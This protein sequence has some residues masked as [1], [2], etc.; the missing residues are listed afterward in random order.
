MM[1]Y[2]RQNMINMSSEKKNQIDTNTITRD[3][4]SPIQTCL[5]SFF[6]R[7]FFN[8]FPLSDFYMIKIFILERIYKLMN[9]SRRNQSTGLQIKF[10]SLVCGVYLAFLSRLQLSYLVLIR[11]L[12]KFAVVVIFVYLHRLDGLLSFSLLLLSKV[13]HKIN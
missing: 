3:G 12:V 2:S 6:H 5:Q 7:I 10:N 1:A 11:C 4:F 13:F 9:S 8:E